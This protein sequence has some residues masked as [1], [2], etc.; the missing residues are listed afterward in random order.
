M[1]K[2]SCKST[3]T[4]HTVPNPLGL[5]PSVCSIVEQTE[6]AQR[7]ISASARAIHRTERG[8]SFLTMCAGL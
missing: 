2:M 5:F 7:D 1:H 4:A 3:Q 8:S 6:R